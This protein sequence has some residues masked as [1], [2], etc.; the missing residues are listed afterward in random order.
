MP[1][2]ADAPLAKPDGA[3]TKR[4]ELVF[5]PSPG[6]AFG[7][8]VELQIL[9]RDS[10]DLA[11]GAPR[12]LKACQEDGIDGT[13]AEL[14]QSMIEVKT[15]ICQ[16]VDEARDQLFARVRRL[17]NIA[18]SLGYDLALGSTHP[19]HRA[20]TSTIFPG[21][22]YEKILHR[23][24]WVT[25]QRVLFGLHVHVAMP[26]GEVA[27]GVNNFLV[28]YIPHLIALSASSPFWQ[29]IDTGL[30]SS[31]T[32]LYRLLPHSGLPPHFS[33]WK[34]FR[35]Y[36]RV[37][38]DCQAMSSFKDIYWDIRPRPDFGTIEIR[39]CDMPSSLTETLSLVALIR[40]LV[41]HA[42][43]LIA[44]RASL[45]RGDIRRHWI[46]IEN[47]W[48]A[49][50]HGLRAMY[51]RGPSGKRRL[52]HT[53]VQDL[54]EKLQPIAREHGDERYLAPFRAMDRFETGSDRQRRLFREHGDWKV[55]VA[56]MRGELERDLEGPAG[57]VG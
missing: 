56:Q 48:L 12:I 30:A 55:L 54:V 26:D 6:H 18:S 10:A 37:M 43:R 3:P 8:E 57:R 2:D 45:R 38:L 20:T 22:R 33:S 14:M 7:V 42:T 32:A 40:S 5:R 23:L 53:D 17:R 31:R 1:S 35:S 49:T 44:E 47:K 52:L 36:C 9:D 39:V 11:P 25:Y 21:E 41:I 15:G 4:D 24:Q 27:I 34:A 19:F 13:A 46:A 50:R 16:S 51:V 29:G 28:R